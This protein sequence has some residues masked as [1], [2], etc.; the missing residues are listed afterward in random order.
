MKIA[1]KF[2]AQFSAQRFGSVAAEYAL[3]LAFLVA[4]IVIAVT[5]LGAKVSTMFASIAPTL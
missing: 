2:L 1:G 3:L 5:A 4:V